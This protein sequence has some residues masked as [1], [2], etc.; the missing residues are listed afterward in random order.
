M[1]EGTRWL[2]VESRDGN[3]D[4]IIF[5][6]VRSTGIYCK[7]SCP[8]RQPR[9]EQVTFFDSQQE[10][11]AAGFRPCRRCRPHLADVRN[12]HLV[13]AEKACQLI[14]ASESGSLS[15]AELSAQLGVSQYHL[16]RTFKGCV[17][18]ISLRRIET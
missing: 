4:G 5:Y 10:A 14:E 13:I 15:L 9:R 6:G 2:A 17:A 11:K 7:P 16:Q 8:S 12:A 18:K 3:L 1:D